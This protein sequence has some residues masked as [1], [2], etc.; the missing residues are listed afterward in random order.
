MVVRRLL[1]ILLLA[2][3]LALA[4]GGHAPPPVVRPPVVTPASPQPSPASQ[5]SGGHTNAWAQW[6]PIVFVGIFFGAVIWTHAT[7]VK[8]KRGC[9]VHSP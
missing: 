8:E 6:A 2:P 3:S 5:P 1:A 4:T 9:Y 7:C